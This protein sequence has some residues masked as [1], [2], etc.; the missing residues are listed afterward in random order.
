M[1]NTEEQ[2]LVVTTV[3]RADVA[4]LSEEI[5]KEERAIVATTEALRD[6][7]ITQAQWTTDVIAASKAILQKRDAIQKLDPLTRDYRQNMMALSYVFNDFFSASGGVQQRL[8]GIANNMPMLL[9]GFGALGPALSGILPILGAMTPA[10]TK[11]FDAFTDAVDKPIP[12][13]DRL[14]ERI[15]ELESIKIRPQVDTFELERARAEVDKIT[16]GIAAF[17]A[18]KN[19]RNATEKEVGAAVAEQLDNGP[20]S[21]ARVSS[22]LRTQFARE[23]TAQNQPLRDTEQQIARHEQGLETIRRQ[24]GRPMQPGEAAALAYQQQQHESSIEK[25]REQS[26]VIWAGINTDATS[27]AGGLIKGAGQG[28]AKSR[29]DLGRRLFNAGR[30]TKDAGLANL[31]QT[32]FNITPEWLDEMAAGEDSLNESIATQRKGQGARSKR[33][34]EEQQYLDENFNS[35]IAGMRQQG[36]KG[37]AK[38]AAAR[39]QAAKNDRADLDATQAA[40]KRAAAQL[41]NTAVGQYAAQLAGQ[42]AGSNTAPEMQ[43]SVLAKSIRD[44][45]VPGVSAGTALELAKG[46]LATAKANQLQFSGNTLG[47]NAGAAGSVDEMGDQ[48][49]RMNAALMAN[50]QQMELRARQAAMRLEQ[51]RQQFVEQ[52]RAQ[53]VQSYIYGQGW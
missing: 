30:S 1:G 6:Q 35:G 33:E 27:R 7:R 39:D 28:D 37:R 22:V 51:Q 52:Q 19:Q 26:R 48:M 10:I 4:A 9:L 41:V 21:S 20:V 50:Q 42:L 36:A 53:Q 32:I 18:Y 43:Q 16:E 38:D 17:N 44:Q 13:L 46:S 14:K 40:A 25:L 5:R 34:Q 15:K 29:E 11:A 8:N 47:I 3:G 23:E 45:R 24:R 31:G 12:R 49:A 2:K